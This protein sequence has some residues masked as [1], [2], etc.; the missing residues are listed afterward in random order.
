MYVAG[1]LQGFGTIASVTYTLFFL[2]N[3]LSQTEISMLFSFFMINLAIM[4]IPTGAFSDTLGH[5]TSIA[6]GT[7][8]FSLSFC[9]LLHPDKYISG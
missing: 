6:L 5:K 4:E 7:F 3:G 1:F 8:I 2:S 9:I